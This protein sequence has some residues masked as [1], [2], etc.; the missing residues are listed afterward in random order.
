M[1]KHQKKCMV[2]NKP[3]GRKITTNHNPELNVHYDVYLGIEKYGKYLHK[4]CWQNLLLA[5]LDSL[6]RETQTFQEIMDIKK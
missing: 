4:R 1:K 6:L 2:C 5:C 3:V